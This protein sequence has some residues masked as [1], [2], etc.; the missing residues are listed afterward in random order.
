MNSI[1]IGPLPPGDWQ[2]FKQIRLEALQ[3]NP[4]AFSNTYEDV[5]TYPDEKWQQQMDESERKDG[6]FF[7]FAFDG[8]IIVGMNGMYWTKKPVT[9]HVAEIFGVFVKPRYRG[10]GIGKRLMEGI[11]NEITK[12]P[13]F[14]KMKLGVNAENLPA[15]KLYESCG[16][17]VVGTLKNE[18]HFGN[19]YCNELLMEKILI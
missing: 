4:T 9:K 7:L 3:T 5:A 10:I 1:T 15:L 14:T 13:Q 2:K 11:I 12:N 17:T 6:S 8:E 19:N 18:L 16:L